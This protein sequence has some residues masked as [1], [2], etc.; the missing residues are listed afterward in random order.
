MPEAIREEIPLS[1]NVANV[2]KEGRLFER[3]PN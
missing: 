3:T 1:A 2:D